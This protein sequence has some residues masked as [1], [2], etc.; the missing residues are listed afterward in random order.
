MVHRAIGATTLLAVSTSLAG[1]GDPGVTAKPAGRTLSGQ[2]SLPVEERADF[3]RPP[4][5]QDQFS[6]SRDEP[7]YLAAALRGE[8][9]AQTKVGKAYVTGAGDPVT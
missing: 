1:P 5:R 6:S 7:E 4:V 9:W 8:A 2:A 3:S